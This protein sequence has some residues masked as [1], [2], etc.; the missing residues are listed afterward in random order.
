M[1]E[2]VP[3][4]AVFALKREGYVRRTQKSRCWDTSHVRTDKPV[5][6]YTHLFGYKVHYLEVV[7][8]I[9]AVV[10]RLPNPLRA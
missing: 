4:F 3:H 9:L 6:N 10:K 8:D 1:R 5:K 7:W 2:N